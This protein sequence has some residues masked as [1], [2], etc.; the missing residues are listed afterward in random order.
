[1]PDLCCHLIV[2]ANALGAPLRPKQ[3]LTRIYADSGR[4]RALP[5]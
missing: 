1:M 2:I 5:P 3:A 4:A